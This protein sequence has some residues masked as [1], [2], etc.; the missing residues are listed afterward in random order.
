MKAAAA[1]LHALILAGG[2]S[3]R[4]RQDKA[5]LMYQGRSQ[6]DRAFDLAGR[7]VADVFV[8]VRASQ[9][10]DPGRSAKPLILDSAD[11]EGPIVGIRSALAAHPDVAWLVIACDLPFLS[12]AALEQLLS[13]RDPTRLA[14]AFLSSFDGLPE[15]LC[16]VWEPEAAAALSA[17][18]EAGGRCPRKFLMRHPARLLEPRDPRALDNVNTPEEYAHAQSVL[19]NSRSNTLP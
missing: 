1:P 14:T 18:H 19:C 8:S 15:P 16:A 17:Y 4:M 3:T 12:D 10:A 11:G 13:E 6:L 9:T 5:A 7:H 2:A